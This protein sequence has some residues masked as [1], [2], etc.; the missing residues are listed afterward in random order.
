MKLLA[1]FNIVLILAFGLGMALI[2]HYAHSFLMDNAEQQIVREAELMA[3]S[4]SAT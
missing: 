3:A 1:K 4:A 2:A